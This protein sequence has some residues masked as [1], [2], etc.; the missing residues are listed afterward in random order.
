MCIFLVEKCHFAQILV[1]HVNQC[2]C[3][4][5]TGICLLVCSLNLT[6]NFWYFLVFLQSCPGVCL[7]WTVL[8]ELHMLLQKAEGSGF[9]GG[10]AY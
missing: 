10:E 1:D 2:I 4:I 9:W 8:Q 6:N 3:T 5:F 7:S